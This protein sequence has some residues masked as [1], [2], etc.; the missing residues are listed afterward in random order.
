MGSSGAPAQPERSSA[1]YWRKPI[2]GGVWSRRTGTRR[3][4]VAAH[5][6]LVAHPVRAGRRL[7]PRDDHGGGGG[8]FGLDHGREGGTS[9]DL[10]VGPE[11]EPARFERIGERV[12]ALRI[13]A[14]VAQE[15]A[16]AVCRVRADFVRVHRATV[17][18]RIR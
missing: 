4:L 13:G 18:W 14:G 6:R 3:P 11:L 16:R 9:F 2:G 7:G 1:W 10:A 17:T 15:H 8:E 12:R 5:G